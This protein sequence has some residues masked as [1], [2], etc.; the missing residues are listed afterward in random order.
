M[1]NNLKK[2]LKWIFLSLS[3]LIISL[4]VFIFYP[5][6]KKTKI[7]YVTVAIQKGDLEK[8]VEAT[9]TINPVNI[10][11]V[12]T[13]VSGI[14]KKIYID[15]NDRVKK[16]QILAELDKSVLLSNKESAKAKMEK[17]L[18]QKELAALEVKRLQELFSKKYIARA[19]LDKAE[20]EFKSCLA[21]YNVTLSEYKK[22]NTNLS[23]AIILSPV[24][25]VVISREVDEGQTVSASLQAP[26]L[27]KIAE[28][29]TKMQIETS[30]S[31]AD[32]GFIKPKQQV[33]FTVDAFQN[34]TFEGQV[35][36]IRLNPE[37]Q[38][39]VVTYTVVINIENSDLKLLPGMTA[40]TTILINKKKDILKIP[41][42]AF[43]FKGPKTSLEKKSKEKTSSQEAIL[44]L[45]KENQT[46]KKIKVF[47]GVSNDSETEII[48]SEINEND[49]V[50][51]DILGEDL[52]VENQRL[53]ERAKGFMLRKG[54]SG[55]KK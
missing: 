24:S 38:E 35:R 32:I 2:K 1:K 54:I 33:T 48:S 20:A 36:Q 53:K 30:I 3:F 51:E 11:N 34:E 18:T 27:F 55:G 43:S 26:E 9:G 19:E 5:K 44:Y 39:N 28:D 52:K 47:K 42:T 6:D 29:L 40:F 10:V 14:I 45:L 4:L 15:F 37:S 22:A 17:A 41:N 23:Y 7:E 46:I 31:E 21:D 49:L 50:I 8:K 12:G 25:G 16:G 13:Q